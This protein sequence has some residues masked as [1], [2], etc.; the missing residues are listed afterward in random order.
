METLSGIARPKIVVLIA[1][2]VSVVRVFLFTQQFAVNMMFWDQWSIYSAFFE[3]RGLIDA[4]RLQQ[5]PHRQGLGALLIFMVAHLTGWDS[6]ADSY[7]VAAVLVA[8]T[9][10]AL[11]LKYRLA[12]R[13]T[14]ADVCIPL[15]FLNVNQSQT[16]TVVPNVS[17]SAL[18]LLLVVLYALAL[19]LKRAHI[20]MLV[21]SAINFLLLYTGFGIFAAF[22]TPV[23]FLLRSLAPA[24]MGF[25]PAT[26]RVWIAGLVLSVLALGT[27]FVDWRLLTAADCAV[28]PHPRPLEYLVFAG[29]QISQGFAIAPRAPQLEPAN[30][31][32]M[33]IGLI[34]ALG[35]IVIALKTFA[36]RRGVIVAFLIS[37]SLLFVANTAVGRVCLGATQQPLSSKYS[38]LVLPM[39]L[40]L[41]LWASDQGRAWRRSVGWGAV[42]L[43]ALSLVPPFYRNPYT[44]EPQL[45]HDAK[46]KWSACY[47]AKLDPFECDIVAGYPMYPQTQTILPFLYDLEKN[48]LNLFKD[49]ATDI[50]I[51]Q[52]TNGVPLTNTH[53]ELIG[54]IDPAEFEHYELQWGAGEFPKNWE[55]VSG[56]HMSP[57]HNGRLGEWDMTHLSPGIYTIRASI[58]LK[59]GTQRRAQVRVVK[60]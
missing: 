23:L 28:F 37:F 50:Q 60:P 3:E 39:L 38:T 53:V 57:V 42:A 21:L 22:L 44:L 6:R 48:H 13:F 1:L 45:F 40:G 34:I 24:R 27:F 43:L 10:A 29:L 36:S 25:E 41:L 46:V 7:L 51:S 11:V 8:A 17:H 20:Q 30:A 32:A 58:F 9:I 18:P 5:G 56:P 26:R 31:L 15:L 59:D 52:P 33:G 49:A 2:A 14:W 12:G 54:T 19:T 4:F 47:L 35:S 55:W 16:L